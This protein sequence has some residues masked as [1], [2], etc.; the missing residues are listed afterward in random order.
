MTGMSYGQLKKIVD[1]VHQMLD[2]YGAENIPRGADCYLVAELTAKVM[3]FYGEDAEICCGPLPEFDTRINIPTGGTF[4]GR[5]W[6]ETAE[7]L[8][9]PTWNPPKI[10]PLGSYKKDA[11]LLPKM[12]TYCDNQV[13]AQV[14]MQLGAAI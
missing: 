13:V 2:K 11:S 14:F 1:A 4:D 8:I 7:S 9:D 6:V 10:V 12:G 3:Q 5:C